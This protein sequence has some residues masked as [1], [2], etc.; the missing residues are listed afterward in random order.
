MLASCSVA[1]LPK[2]AHITMTSTTDDCLVIKISL[3][4]PLLHIS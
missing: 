4:S 1:R 2:N 3:T